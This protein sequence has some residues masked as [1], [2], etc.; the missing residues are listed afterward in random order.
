MLVVISNISAEVERE[1]L[2]LQGQRTWWSHHVHSR[3]GEGRHSPA[4]AARKSQASQGSAAS[5][6]EARRS[7]VLPSPARSAGRDGTEKSIQGQS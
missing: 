1:R 5:R 3:P 4:S 2:E 7:E 6:S